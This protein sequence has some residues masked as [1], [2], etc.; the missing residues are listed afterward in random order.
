[1]AVKIFFG[2]KYIP[3]NIFAKILRVRTFF[4][5]RS[6]FFEMQVIGLPS[7]PAKFHVARGMW[8][9]GRR[10]HAPDRAVKNVQCS[11][12]GEAIKKQRTFYLNLTLFG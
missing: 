7:K 9:A 2:N 11:K 10:L 12:I 3:N 4:F 1:M 5:W 6:V 8:P